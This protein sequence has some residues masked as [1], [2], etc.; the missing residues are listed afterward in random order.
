MESFSRT[1]QIDSHG[2]ASTI[3]LFSFA[4]PH[5]R[6]LHLVGIIALEYCLMYKDDIVHSRY[7]VS[8]SQGWISFMTAFLSWYSI[9]PLIS[10]IQADLGLSAVCIVETFL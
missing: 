8:S 6:A 1:L 4:R 2:K 5:M 7:N 10:I 3:K 9:P